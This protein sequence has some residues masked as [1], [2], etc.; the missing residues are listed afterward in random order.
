MQMTVRKDAEIEDFKTLVERQLVEIQDLKKRL[1]AAEKELASAVDMLAEK[2]AEI[3]DLKK[4]LEAVKKQY[5]PCP[6][7]IADLRGEVEAIAAQFAASE[8]QNKDLKKRL[9]AAESLIAEK[10][11]EIEDLKKQLEAVKKRYAEL[12]E[13]YAPYDALIQ[14]LQKQLASM[15]DQL[16]ALRRQIKETKDAV[17][18]DEPKLLNMK[19]KLEAETA[20]RKKQ[21]EVKGGRVKLGASAPPKGGALPV[22]AASGAK[23]KLKFGAMDL[24]GDGLLSK[25]EFQSKLGIMRWSLEEAEQTFKD[26][27]RDGD[28]GISAHEYAAFCQMEDKNLEL[29]TLNGIAKLR[30]QLADLQAQLAAMASKDASKGAEIEDLKKRLAEITAAKQLLARTIAAHEATIT[31]RDAEIQTLKKLIAEL[32][33]IINL[34]V[35]KPA[36]VLAIAP[37]C[38]VTVGTSHICVTL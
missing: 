14:S 32:K 19:V 6:G 9:A 12:E 15:E 8:A 18:F 36:P 28:G 1:A 23:N 22:P 38:L 25:A 21:L 4:Q 2:D 3:E 30:Q 11:A 37:M 16:D 10:D 5:A 17:E 27:D 7:T 13:K 29:G 35:S 24:D 33:N 26:M 34:K 20:D 31:D